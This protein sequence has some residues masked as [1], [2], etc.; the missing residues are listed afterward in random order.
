MK[1]RIIFNCF[2]LLATIYISTCYPISVFATDVKVENIQVVKE[3]S[4]A[5]ALKGL[6][7]NNENHPIKGYVKIKFVNTNGDIVASHSAYVNDGDQI[8]PRQAG[9]FKYYSSP[10]EFESVTHYQII[11]KESY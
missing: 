1:H 9:P 3:H 6:I 11:F 7:R 5:W 4:N 8:A 10:N 2:V